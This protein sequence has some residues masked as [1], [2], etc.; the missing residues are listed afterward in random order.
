MVEREAVSELVH[1]LL[2]T[3]RGIRIAEE[4]V[5]LASGRMSCVYFNIGDEVISYPKVRN[6]VIQ[7]LEKVYRSTGLWPRRWVGVPE[8]ANCL[9]AI[10]AEKTVIGQLRVHET[11]TDHGDQRSIE[12]Y[13]EPNT[14]VGIVEDV[15][16]TGLSTITRSIEPVRAVGLRPNLVIAL[17]DRQYGGVPKL[18]D[19]GIT[20][21]AFT[22][23]T[24]IAQC[25]VDE[26][27]V[28]DTQIRLLRE[29]LEEL[30]TVQ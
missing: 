8:G 30:K 17:I 4:R 9:A 26:S 22:T 16:S 12:G 14:T 7:A 19:M 20:T 27:L 11:Q 25:L 18:R 5:K 3:K 2:E 1:G 10:L 24:E 23:T 29:E 15:I 6:V 21:K 28:N 13:F